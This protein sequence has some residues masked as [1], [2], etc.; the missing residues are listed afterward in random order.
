MK[1]INASPKE[2][3]KFGITF[4][5]LSVGLVVFLLYRG[6]DL[7]MLFVGSAIFFLLTGL[8]AYAILKPVYVG[9]M[10]F[11]FAL[12]WVNARIILGVVFYLIFTPIGLILRLFRK[13]L[14]NLRFN[15]S[16]TTYWTKRHPEKFSN[17][18]YEQLF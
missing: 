14:L 4:S 11:A 15:K 2:V 5:I 6:N 10:T 8:F 16:A 12:G 13:D 7:W 1:Q 3:R 9:W 18:R 17:K